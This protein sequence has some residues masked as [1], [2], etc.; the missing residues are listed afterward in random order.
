[1]E[2]GDNM[3][4]K[5]KNIQKRNDNKSSLVVVRGKKKTVKLRSGESI[6][7]G[8]SVQ[9]PFLAPYK[10][11]RITYVEYV[12]TTTEDGKQ[13]KRGVKVSG[14]GKFGVPTLKDKEVLRALQDIYIWSKIEDGIL[15]LETDLSKVTEED[16]LIDFKTIDNVGRELGYKKISGQQR[17][18]IKESIEILVAT[19]FINSENGGLYD[20]VT[21]Q[22]ITNS[23][24]TFRYIDKMK[25]YTTYDCENCLF[26]GA[27]GKNYE[28]CMDEANKRTDVT[29][30]MM[31]KFMYSNIANN[32]RLYYERNKVNQ[33]KNLI[34]KNIYS[35]SRKWIGNGYIS[36]ANIQ[37]YIDRIPMNA[38]QE[39]HRKQAIKDAV[40]ILNSYD[41]VNAWIE[42][43]TV[44]VEHLDKKNTNNNFNVT[45]KL[46][47]R[48][49]SYLKD[50]FNSFSEFKKGLDEIGFTDEDFNKIIDPNIEKIEYFK[51]LLRYVLLKSHYDSKLDTR[52]Y[53]INF[54]KANKEI[55]KKYYGSIE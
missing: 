44:V 5:D 55:D 2:K 29:K 47:T 12:W 15:E 7:D 23:T 35:I 4:N 43:E 28:S 21:G 8:N 53:F 18:A 37:R 30:I 24:E 36:R 42:E 13:I 11:E 48:D 1:M 49:T 27:C 52:Q 34:A 6:M 14:H 54:F 40:A 45:D 3:S 39:K 20:P 9:M 22:Y 38:K 25:D 19:T 10:G 32:Y 50:R 16:L 17:K 31:S 26:L 41:F 46:P 33:I 51:A